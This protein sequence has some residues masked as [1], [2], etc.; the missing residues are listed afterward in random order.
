MAGAV[1][2][3]DPDVVMAFR[4]V[5]AILNDDTDAYVTTLTEVR[6]LDHA[7]R[8]ITA[9]T[10]QWA[11][12][13]ATGRLAT[14]IAKAVVPL[15]NKRKVRRTRVPMGEAIRSSVLRDIQR[16]LASQLDAKEEKS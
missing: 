4:L 9:L 14:N 3:A 12:A 6:S 10:T 8:V 5:L 7:D 1:M 13:L 2:T 11:G 16:E 15:A